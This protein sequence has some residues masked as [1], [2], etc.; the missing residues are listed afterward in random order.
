MKGMKMSNK[1]DWV[2]VA[3]FEEDVNV[4]ATE[5]T[6]T[7]EELQEWM[8]EQR[9]NGAAETFVVMPKKLLAEIW[10]DAEEF[11]RSFH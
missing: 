8:D 9:A 7:T 4:L 3:Q 5:F 10:E 6:G 1:A 11:G 2:I